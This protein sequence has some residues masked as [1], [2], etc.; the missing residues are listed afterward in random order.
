VKRVALSLAV[1]VLAALS[2]CAPKT[3]AI[4]PVTAPKFP[5]FIFPAAPAGLG[6]PAIV[7]RH[8]LG[9]RWLQAGDPRAA[10]RNFSAVLKDS[11]G[12]YPACA[13]GARRS[14]PR[15]GGS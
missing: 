7:E 3:A 13:G 12:F 9:W 2:A 6:S 10:D 8:D 11:A 15:A 5:D 1:M 14:A 4:P